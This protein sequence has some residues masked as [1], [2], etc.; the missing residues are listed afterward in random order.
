MLDKYEW[1]FQK[2]NYMAKYLGK[3]SLEIIK[4]LNLKYKTK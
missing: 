4:K 2:T 1:Y 3:E